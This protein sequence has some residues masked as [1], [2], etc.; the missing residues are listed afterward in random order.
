MGSS[1]SV[2]SE[3]EL[4]PELIE[5]IFHKAGRTR[6]VRAGE[7]FIREGDLVASVFL[8]TEGAAALKKRTGQAGPAKLLGSRGA[9]A[10]IGELSFLLGVP[11]S[12][13]VEA[14][15]PSTTV[16]E[17]PQAELMRMLQ[18]DPVLA[19]GFFRLLGATLAE[20]ITEMSSSMRKAVVHSGHPTV[21]RGHR[22]DAALTILPE[23]LDQPVSAVATAFGLPADAEMVLH[24]ECVVAIEENS[25]VDGEM[26]SGKL[27]LF[28]TH[29]CFDFSLFGFNSRRVVSLQDMLAV[30]LAVGK[31]QPKPNQPQQQVLDIECKGLSLTLTLPAAILDHVAR[32]LEA[33]RVM[34]LDVSSALMDDS[35]DTAQ[36]SYVQAHIDSSKAGELDSLSPAAGLSVG[37]ES[38]SRKPSRSDASPLPLRQKHKQSTHLVARDALAPDSEVMKLMQGLLGG[39]SGAAS[40]AEATGGPSTKRDASKPPPKSVGGSDLAN[41]SQEQWSLFLCG[42]DKLR[43]KRGETV[44]KEGDGQRALYQVVEGSLRVE[45]SVKGRPQAVVVGHRKAGEMFGERSLL[46]GGN[47]AAS[48]VVDSDECVM[49]RLTSGF[50]RELF[51]SHP[52]LLG[53]FFCLLAVDQAKRLSQLT[54]ESEQESMALV[55][56]EGLHAPRDMRTLVASSAY[57]T[58][59]M[60]Y[61]RTLA[62]S[63]HSNGTPRKPGAAGG[64]PRRA[65]I[66][67]GAA[68]GNTPRV[69]RRGQQAA[70]NTPRSALSSEHAPTLNQLEFVTELRSVRSEPD[71]A[72]LRTLAQQTFAKFVGAAAYKPVGCVTADEVKALDGALAKCESM[73]PTQVRS[74]P[75]PTVLPPSPQF[76]ALVPPR[77]SASLALGPA[78]PARAIRRPS[79]IRSLRRCGRSST[80]S[81][82]SW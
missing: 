72:T 30:R 82:R 45:L 18:R 58:I 48:V 29:A 8:I 59:L 19:G 77:A 71:P 16:M 53:K 37:S 42:S 33:T 68:A 57:L 54:R 60:R 62:F 50:L 44:I 24:C 7:R 69:T 56:P 12:V 4:S 25:V 39:G 70:G 26:H 38:F 14:S 21:K 66:G 2:M 31:Q 61:V 75:P 20:R 40:A 73:P 3:T 27:Y 80:A 13:T 17:L 46:L 36:D 15:G 64:T 22:T 52:E 34:A 49:V 47:A 35:V 43:F 23:A 41:L 79:C 28:E 10:L 55:L 74:P 65:P 63:T 78:L 81:R 9:G 67:G 11:A 76:L 32:E 5:L 1:Q 6:K 51:A